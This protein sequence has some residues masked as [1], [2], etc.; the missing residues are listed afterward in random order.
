MCY[1]RNLKNYFE[2]FLVL[3]SRCFNKNSEECSDLVYSPK[4]ISL[5]GVWGFLW[6]LCFFKQSGFHFRPNH[7]L[8]VLFILN[9]L[10]KNLNLQSCCNIQL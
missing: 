7:A 9:F 2:Q 8:K 5:V 6:V 1:F 3:S 10:S 4:I